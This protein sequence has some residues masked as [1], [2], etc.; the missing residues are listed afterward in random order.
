MM[1]FF[2][3]FTHSN[4]NAQTT[5]Q[6]EQH[7]NKCSESFTGRKYTQPNDTRP[8]HKQNTLRRHVNTYEYLLKHIQKDTTFV[9]RGF[10]Q[11]QKESSS[12]L[13]ALPFLFP[14]S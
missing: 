8:Y 14:S 9:Q 3:L 2:L 7:G 1:G 5:V 6:Q 4:N 12:L 11:I 13:T 10:N